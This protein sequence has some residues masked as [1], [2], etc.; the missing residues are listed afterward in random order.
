LVEFEKNS[1]AVPAAVR[2]AS[3]PPSEGADAL[4]TAGKGAGATA[5]G[6]AKPAHFY[7]AQ[8]GYI[9]NSAILK[10]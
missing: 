6:A 8:F 5:T 1:A 7:L 4:A 3:F 10:E 9:I 2:R